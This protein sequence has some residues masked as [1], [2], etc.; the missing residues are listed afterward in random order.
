MSDKFSFTLDRERGIVRIV[1]R[2]FYELSDV[3]DFFEARRRAHAELGL[4]PNQHMTLNDLRG[5]SIQR[6]DVVHALQDGLAMKAEQARRL[7]IVVDA[8]MA[9]G[10]ATRAINSLGT[11]YF[12]DVKT[13]EAWLY[14]DK[15]GAA[16]AA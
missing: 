7:A 12:T 14:A 13:A 2:G 10:Q 6:Q 16:R 5:M 9:R 11:R 15:S 3:A 1:M 4:P 8:A